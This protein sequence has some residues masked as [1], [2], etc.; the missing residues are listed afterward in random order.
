MP[1]ATGPPS[2]VPFGP[3]DHTDNSPASKAARIGESLVKGSRGTE[4]RR[5]GTSDSI[6]ALVATE[7]NRGLL[8]AKRAPPPEGDHD[9][10][11]LAAAGWVDAHFPAAAATVATISWS[12]PAE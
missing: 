6:A 1:A 3:T 4:G 10:E 8:L 11:R 2:S 9:L 7:T 12:A 5:A